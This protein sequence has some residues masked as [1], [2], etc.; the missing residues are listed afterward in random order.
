MWYHLTKELN[1]LLTA[2]GLS[3]ST[4]DDTQ[5]MKS[6]LNITGQAINSGTYA[7]T[8]LSA[9]GTYIFTGSST[10]TLPAAPQAGVRFTFKAKNNATSVISANAGQTIGTTNSTSFS[11]YAQED[12]VTL[13]W[14]GISIWYV[15]ATNGPVQSS[16]QTAQTTT[17]ATGAWT[18]IANGFSL[19]TLSP[20]VYDFELDCVVLAQASSTLGVSIGNVT[21]PIAPTKAVSIAAVGASVGWESHVSVRGY[22]LSAAAVIQG[23]YYS[24]SAANVI[25]YQ[26]ANT[27]GRITVRRIG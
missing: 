10:V 7:G 6:V 11:L 14:D 4:I 15:V 23:L 18:A 1:N 17:S 13:E 3:Q 22:V 9:P 16:S 26:N 21:T 12:Y 27:I 25:Y 20:G 2:A 19:G 5:I 24:T 8:L